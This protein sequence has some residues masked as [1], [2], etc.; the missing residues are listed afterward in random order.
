VPDHHGK[1]SH[2]M[3]CFEPDELDAAADFWRQA[4]GVEFEDVAL[5]D[6]GLRILFAL[7]AGLELLAPLDDRARPKY[8]A[9]L[10]RH[11]GGM[12]GL[13]YNVGDIE[14]A[15]A[16]AA[17]AGAAIADRLSYSDREPWSLEFDKFEE[18]LLEEHLGMRVVI[19]QI[20][21]RPP[22]AGGA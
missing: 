7:D 1:V 6:S 5:P 4:F 14:A 21:R 13:V 16:R 19:A 10:D 22:P 11:G 18:S 17:E 20:D 3:F 8:R 2:V 9:F 15:T 12:F